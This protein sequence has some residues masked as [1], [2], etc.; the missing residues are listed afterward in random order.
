ML[1]THIP[2]PEFKE[3]YELITGE[4]EVTSNTPDYSIKEDGNQI[5]FGARRET[6]CH[7][8]HNSGMFDKIL[9]LG[10]TQAVVSGHDHV[11]DFI[12]NYK[13]VRLGYCQSSGYS[14]YN[15]AT[16]GTG[17]A[18]LQG[19]SEFLIASNGDL[20][21]NNKKNADLWPELQNDIDN[22]YNS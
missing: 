8:G 2:L 6:I 14:S 4:K 12:L 17:E 10:S 11:N 13:G 9:S 15:L 7:S 1:F 3:A 19:Y 22:L 16:R 20:E 5:L 21:W 18:L